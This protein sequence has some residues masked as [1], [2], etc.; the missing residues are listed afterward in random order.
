MLG[1]VEDQIASAIDQFAGAGRDWNAAMLTL[2]CEA[3]LQAMRRP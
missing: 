2:A 1:A 3:V